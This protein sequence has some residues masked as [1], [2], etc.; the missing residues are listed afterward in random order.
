[1]R[2][3]I[4][5]LLVLASCGG[6]VAHECPAAIAPGRHVVAATVVSSDCSG[7]QPTGW[8][9]AGPMDFIGCE[10]SACSV[11]CREGVESTALTWNGSSWDYQYTGPACS[12]LYQATVE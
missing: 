11:V 2:T 8:S 4:A 3:T 7:Q 1:M 9:W 6:R 10:Q 5:A 12:V